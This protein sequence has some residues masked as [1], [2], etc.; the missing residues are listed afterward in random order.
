MIRVIDRD[1]CIDI[2]QAFPHG[3]IAN[4]LKT[5]LVCSRCQKQQIFVCQVYCPLDGHQYDRTLYLFACRN[6]SCW[7][8]SDRFVNLPLRFSL[9]ILL[10]FSWTAVRC[11]KYDEAVEKAVVTPEEPSAIVPTSSKDWCD[12]ADAWNSDDDDDN[13]DKVEEKVPSV[14]TTTV[15]K[16]LEVVMLNSMKINDEEEEDRNGKSSS[17]EEE[18][19][20][21]TNT[22]NKSKSKNISVASADAF[23]E[24]KKTHL[25]RPTI[26]LSI[27]ATFPF[28]YIVI[29]D[30]DDIVD[31]A[32][33]Y[34]QRKL[35]SKMNKL[36]HIDEDD[37]DETAKGGKE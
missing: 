22:K 31:E 27:D 17:D 18:E 33:L 2:F 8:T 37:D 12:D 29:D 16:E 15:K 3:E 5:T 11:Q 26:D 35:R 19:E 32:K 13:N 4:Q 10:V 7:N 23:N 34:E 36:G 14:P 24:W 21:E 28:Y 9:F 30:E 20:I 25:A 1:Q 6:P